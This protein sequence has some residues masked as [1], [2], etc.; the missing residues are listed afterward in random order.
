MKTLPLFL[1]ATVTATLN[2][3]QQQFVNPFAHQ[4]TVGIKSIHQKAQRT[5]SVGALKD[6]THLYL[7]D[8]VS[9]NWTM[10]RTIYSYDLNNNENYLITYRQTPT[11]WQPIG[12]SINYSYDSNTNLLSVTHQYFDVPSSA[13]VNSIKTNAA[14]NTANDKISSTTLRW[15]GS[16][17]VNDN[18][19]LYTYDSNHNCLSINTQTFNSTTSQW[20][21][22]TLYSYAYDSNN[23]MILDL[24][25]QWDAA[26]SS[27]IN[28]ARNTATFNS[29]NQ[30]LSYI[31]DNWNASA[32]QWETTSR[33][34]GITYT[35]SDLTYYEIETLNASTMQYSLSFR[36]NMNY[37]SNHNMT[38]YV[39]QTYNATSG[40]WENTDKD[41]LTYNSSNNQVA[42]LFYVGDQSTGGWKNF[43]RQYDYYRSSVGIN[44]LS[45]MESLVCVYPNPVR[46]TLMIKAN[47]GLSLDGI[48]VLD[49]SGR[50]V[51]SQIADDANALSID[52]STLVPGIYTVQINTKKGPIYKKMIKE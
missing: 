41:D 9:G 7:L 28:Q 23:N 40:Q 13:W 11:L 3:Q 16:G 27:W 19:T 32:S 43:Q 46:D 45:S 34:T 50:L 31:S 30:Y 35:G 8:F 15:N 25:Q 37:D 18:Q 14:Y 48:S 24:T 33:M 1:L 17:W 38:G 47:E 21:N 49:I 39:S 29:S 20:D 6:S 4:R 22:E 26:G 52:L 51:V 2:A 10:D 36:V 5:T 12:Q 44:E 42:G